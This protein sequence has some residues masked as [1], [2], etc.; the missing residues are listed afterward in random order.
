MQAAFTV[1]VNCGLK[2]NFKPCGLLNALKAHMCLTQLFG[3]GEAEA[4]DQ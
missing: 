2:T 3:H 4:D 1:R